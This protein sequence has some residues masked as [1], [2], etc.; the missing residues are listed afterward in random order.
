LVAAAP[1]VF[2]DAKIVD[3]WRRMES[4]PHAREVGLTAM[5][6]TPQLST[7]IPGFKVVPKRQLGALFHDS[8]SAFY[9]LLGRHGDPGAPRESVLFVDYVD[10]LVDACQEKIDEL[11]DKHRV[12][13]THVAVKLGAHLRSPDRNLTHAYERALAVQALRNKLNPRFRRI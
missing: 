9:V 6:A 5:N 1:P 11:W 10:D 8:Q 2:S 3:W 4:P 7:K 12:I 13:I